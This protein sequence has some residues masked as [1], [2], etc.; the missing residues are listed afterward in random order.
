MCCIFLHW[1]CAEVLRINA[2]LLILLQQL[3]P[4]ARG[5]PCDDFCGSCDTHRF[6][7]L[8]VLLEVTPFLP[9]LVRQTLLAERLKLSPS[10]IAL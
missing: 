3:L 10:I 6:A 7:Y 9:L 8:Q 5:R 2:L 4:S 1:V